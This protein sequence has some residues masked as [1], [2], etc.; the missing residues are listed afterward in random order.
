MKKV[1]MVAMVYVV[2]AYAHHVLMRCTC[3]VCMCCHARSCMRCHPPSPPRCPSL[4]P[5]FFFPPSFFLL[6]I[7]NTVLWMHTWPQVRHAQSSRHAHA[8][9]SFHSHVYRY[10]IIC[11]LKSVA[12]HP[13]PQEGTTVSGTCTPRGK[14]RGDLC[15]YH[16]SLKQLLPAQLTRKWDTTTCRP[17]ILSRCVLT[18]TTHVRVSLLF[19]EDFLL[20]QQGTL[21]TLHSSR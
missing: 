18:P 15:I 10:A 3:Y 12:T 7:V 21:Q 19:Q 20:M 13:P 1:A 2:C 9:P 5:L 4:E 17:H 14:D 11:F 6:L 16:H 8:V